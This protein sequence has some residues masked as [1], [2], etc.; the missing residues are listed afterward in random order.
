MD[1]P[2]SPLAPPPEG[3]PGA[4]A[5]PHSPVGGPGGPGGSPMLSP[6]GG[7]GNKAAAVQQVK[8]VMPAIMMAMMAFEAG[9]K[10]QQALNRALSAL[11]PIFGK[12]EGTNLVPAAL[13]TM[14]QAQKQ[15]PLSAAP[16]PGLVSNNSPPPGMGAPPEGAAA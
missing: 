13:S 8:A 12:A 14:A 4:P 1:G 9:S 15:G 16:P 3:P 2:A 11:G 7:A 10:E 6:G 5:V